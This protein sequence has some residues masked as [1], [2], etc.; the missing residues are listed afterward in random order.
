[1]NG[2]PMMVA[3]GYAKDGEQLV[4][5]IL[6]DVIESAEGEEGAMAK[7]AIRRLMFSLFDAPSPKGVLR[8]VFT[9][10]FAYWPELI[11]RMNQNEVADELGCEPQVLNQRIKR[12]KKGKLLKKASHRSETARGCVPAVIIGLKWVQSEFKF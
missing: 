6:P 8:R 11:H 5:V 10:A 7:E 3:A 1:M 2:C 4:P 12:M 9:V